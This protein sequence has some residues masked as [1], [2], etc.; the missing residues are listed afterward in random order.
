ML[1]AGLSKTITKYIK[2]WVNADNLLDE[3][4]DSGISCEGRKITCGM[5]F[6]F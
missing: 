3:K 5:H 2:L 4:Q 6:S 1:H